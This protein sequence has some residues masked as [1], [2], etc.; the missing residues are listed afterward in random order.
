MEKKDYFLSCLLV[1]SLADIETHFID[2]ETG[3]NEDKR[4]IDKLLKDEKIKYRLFYQALEIELQ[5]VLKDVYGI[6]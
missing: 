1:E 4:N 6:R 2:K 5:K 3:K